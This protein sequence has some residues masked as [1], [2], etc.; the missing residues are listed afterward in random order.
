MN[1]LV[2]LVIPVYK[3]EKYLRDC[4]KSAVEQTYDN[5]EIILVDDGSPD[6]CPALCDELATENNDITVIHKTNGGLSSARNAGIEKAKGKYIVFLDS[7]D[8]LAEYA[9]SDMVGIIEKENSAAVFPNTYIKVYENGQESVKA[10]HFTEEMFNADPKIF[11]LEVLIG[12]GRAR[13]STAVLYD[14]ELIKE[15][16]IC[17]LPGRISEDFFFNL[18]FFAVAEKISLYKKPS[19]NNLKRVGS[20]STSYFENFFDT[21]LEMDD[22]VSKFIN[23]L[24][25]EKYKAFIPGRRET[26]LYRNLLIFAINVMGDKNTSYLARQKKCVQ[27]FK[28]KK[29]QDALKS[30][31]TT[32]FFE[33]KFQRLYMGI[34]LKLIRA[35][36]YSLTC[37]F[38]F[39][40]A[41]IN[42]V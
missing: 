25:N 10:S 39:I 27:M 8:T 35:K 40:A 32:P 1:P 22:E 14:L 42:T 33:G 5:I 12:K 24:D 21:V 3:T 37:L 6:G 23:Y 29:F 11:A 18:D 34:S 41:K 38:A 17:Y 16:N 30:G 13:R 28:H 26:L 36:L 20:I 15:K 19:L 4:V 2:S 9:V 7:D 31:A